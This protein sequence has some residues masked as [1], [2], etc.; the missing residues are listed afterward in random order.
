MTIAS[1][2]LP[3]YTHPTRSNYARICNAILTYSVD[4][5]PIYRNTKTDYPHDQSCY[6][7]GTNNINTTQ[8]S[9]DEY[10]SSLLHKYKNQGRGIQIWRDQSTQSN[11]LKNNFGTQN[12]NRDCRNSWGRQER[13][14]WASVGEMKAKHGTARGRPVMWSGLPL[15]I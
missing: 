14:D 6:K 12:E 2:E 7:I 15:D 5:T 13:L 11:K 4:Q 1:S 9:I 3:S 8:D 10:L